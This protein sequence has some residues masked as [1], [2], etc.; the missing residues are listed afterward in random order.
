MLKILLSLFPLLA[1]PFAIEGQT[2]FAIK[3][4]DKPTTVTKGQT[5]TFSFDIRNRS[6][7]P[8]TLS[9]S[10]AVFASLSWDNEDG[11]GGGTGSGCSERHIPES[12]FFILQ[13]KEKKHFQVAIKIPEAVSASLITVTLKFSPNARGN[14]YGFDALTGSAT[15]TVK[16]P[17]SLN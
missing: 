2:P 13:P 15:A 5:Y 16:L 6:N 1:I 8:I 14:E 11:T 3:V 10:C 7:A 9:S 12:S 17:V 4:V